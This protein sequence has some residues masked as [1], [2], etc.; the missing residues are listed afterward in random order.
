MVVGETGDVGQANYAAS[1][2]GLFRFS[3]SL[4]LEMA[5]K[6]ITVNCVAPGFIDTGMVAAVPAQILDGVIENIPV[7]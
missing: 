2:S 3:R 6:G 4:G 5:K 1:K 7:G